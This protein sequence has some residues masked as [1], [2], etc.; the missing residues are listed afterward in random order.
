MGW[1]GW[2]FVAAI[3]FRI[4]AIFVLIASAFSLSYIQNLKYDKKEKKKEK[5]EKKEKR[6][7]DMGFGSR[8]ISL[9][10]LAIEI[11]TP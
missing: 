10:Y 5:K 7:K 1:T 3:F 2:K 11:S 9:T 4:R 8:T 6:Q